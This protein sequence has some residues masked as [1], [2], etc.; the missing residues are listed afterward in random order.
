MDGEDYHF[1]Q[2]VR[3]ERNEGAPPIEAGNPSVEVQEREVKSW[4][5]IESD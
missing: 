1:G 4:P 5:R 3:R 2:D